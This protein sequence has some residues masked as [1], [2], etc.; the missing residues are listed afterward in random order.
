[1]WHHR[2]LITTDHDLI[3]K[4]FLAYTKTAEF[5]KYQQRR[6]KPRMLLKDKRLSLLLPPLGLLRHWGRHRRYR[7]RVLSL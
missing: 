5:A 6:R 2:H 3:R 4:R 7:K 1:M